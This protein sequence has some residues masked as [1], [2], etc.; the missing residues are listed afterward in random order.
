[1]RNA[2]AT[3]E[4]VVNLATHAVREA[5]NLTSTP[6]PRGVDEL[7]LAGLTPSRR[8]SWRRPGS[9]RAPSTSSAAW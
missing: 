4:F 7:E 6:A 1:M 5:V 2:L 3:G 8:A 9:A